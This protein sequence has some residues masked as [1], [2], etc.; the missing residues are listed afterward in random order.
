MFLTSRTSVRSAAPV[1]APLRSSTRWGTSRVC[2]GTLLMV[3]PF[4]V[5]KGI[6]EPEAARR[7]TAGATAAT[8][9]VWRP[10]IAG[11]DA[12][13]RGTATIWEQSAN[14]AN[15]KSWVFVH[16]AFIAS[17]SRTGRH[18][19]TDLHFQCT[20][21]PLRGSFEKAIGEAIQKRS[22]RTCSHFQERKR[23]CAQSWYN[24]WSTT[25]ELRG[26]AHGHRTLFAALNHGRPED[27]RLEGCSSPAR[28]SSLPSFENV[29]SSSLPSLRRPA[30][31]ACPCP[32]WALRSSSSTVSR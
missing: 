18:S 11:P 8:G 1:S 20:G 32:Y 19:F 14:N 7:A 13:A 10:A 26:C 9:M 4:C 2:A 12:S 15:R 6:V 24:R 3:R 22:R 23:R 30:W 31:R 27:G 16:L 29:R 17:T 5:R 25:T 21:R 28:P